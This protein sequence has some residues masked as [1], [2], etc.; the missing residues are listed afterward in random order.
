MITNHNLLGTIVTSTMMVEEKMK[1]MWL[2]RMKGAGGLQDLRRNTISYQHNRNTCNLPRQQSIPLSLCACWHV[3]ALFKPEIHLTRWLAF[4]WELLIR[5]INR[6]IAAVFAL[7]THRVGRHW[8]SSNII[9]SKSQMEPANVD[10]TLVYSILLIF[11][12]PNYCFPERESGGNG[13]KIGWFLV[14]RILRS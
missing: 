3:H 5:L 14:D 6:T 7:F 1:K 4:M 2:D 13:C 9:R 8:R 10:F 12:L 11:F